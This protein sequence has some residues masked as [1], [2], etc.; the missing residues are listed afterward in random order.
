MAEGLLDFAPV[1][2]RFQALKHPF[3]NIID[4]SY[5]ASPDS[6]TT[7]LK[8][9]ASLFP[10][11]T[12]IV[13]LGG[14]LELGDISE[15]EH[16][17]IG[18]FCAEEI[19]PDLLITVG[20][21]AEQIKEGAVAAKFSDNKILHFNSSDELVEKINPNVFIKNSAIYV[22]GSNGIRLGTVVKFLQT[23]VS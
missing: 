15:E 23:L 1:A 16:R 14:M 20:E 13:V 12:K 19:R 18:A 9:Y 22:K 11:Q 4:D 6:V 2:G 3:L 8:S 17:K 5:N 21:L 7:G 10:T